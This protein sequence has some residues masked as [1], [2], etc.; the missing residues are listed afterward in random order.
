MD[1]ESAFRE[2]GLDRSQIADE[3]RDRSAADQVQAEEEANQP[4]DP[5]IAQLDLASMRMR[6][7][8]EFLL[9][10][11]DQSTDPEMRLKA[12]I[13]RIVVGEG[14]PPKMTVL[15]Q[16]HGF[17]RAAVSL[18][19]RTLLRQL[20]IEPSRFMRPEDEVSSM[21]FSAILRGLNSKNDEKGRFSTPPIGNLLKRGVFDTTRGRPRE[22]RAYSLK[23][24]KGSGKTGQS[25]VN[26]EKK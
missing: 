21:R 18:R 14:N 1:E 12:D 11:C 25:R 9:S 17:S 26:S 16:R 15:A 7:T 8:L 10:G 20:D 5:R 19:C 24:A 22:N 3:K 13:I 2:E 6:A 4:T 23:T